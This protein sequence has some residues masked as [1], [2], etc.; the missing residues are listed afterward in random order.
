VAFKGQLQPNFVVLNEQGA[1]G[2]LRGVSEFSSTG[3]NTGTPKK[4]F[5]EVGV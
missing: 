3:E 4:C 5:R 2:S 1:G